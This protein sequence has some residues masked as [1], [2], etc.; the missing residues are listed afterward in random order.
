MFWVP[1][2]V[3]DQTRFE[4]AVPVENN[5]GGVGEMRVEKVKL[6]HA[7]PPMKFYVL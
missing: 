5:F 4:C 6:F 1:E 7:L 2:D 3:F